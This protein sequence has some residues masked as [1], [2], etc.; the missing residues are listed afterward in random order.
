M[1]VFIVKSY[2]E[3]EKKCLIGIANVFDIDARKWIFIKCFQI[4][5]I[6]QEECLSVGR[7]LFFVFADSA[8]YCNRTVTCCRRR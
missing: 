1:L 7:G 5:L 2:I 4:K 3:T 6:C 8:V